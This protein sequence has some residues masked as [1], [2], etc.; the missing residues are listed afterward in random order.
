MEVDSYV[1]I[2]IFLKLSREPVVILHPML[3]DS[4]YVITKVPEILGILYN[5]DTNQVWMC[6]PD[7]TAPEIVVSYLQMIDLV[8]A[9]VDKAILFFSSDKVAEA[10]SV[11]IMS[12]VVAQLE[13]FSKQAQEAQ[14]AIDFKNQRAI[15]RVLLFIICL[16]Y[17]YIG[18]Q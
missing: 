1:G 10:E 13:Y 2:F 3:V 7:I 18:A 9:E 5:I 16:V 17:E 8:S 15:F 11:R 14:N 4:F 12:E 6:V